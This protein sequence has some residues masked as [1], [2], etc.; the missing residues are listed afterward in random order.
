MSNVLEIN[1]KPLCSIREASVQVS[2]SRDYITRLAREDK[3]VATYIGRQWFVDI[4]SL[5]AYAESKAL[6]Q[7]IRSQH[8]SE[9]RKREQA[10]KAL[11]TKKTEQQNIRVGTFSFRAGAF[12]AVI[13]FC[14][15]GFGTVL[16]QNA[17]WLEWSAPR[18]VQAVDV[19]RAVVIQKDLN[20][21]D[22]NKLNVVPVDNTEPIDI[23][24]EATS[25]IKTLGE[26]KNGI[27]LLPAG[28]DDVS[29][30]DLF[31]DPVEVVRLK[32]GT[33]ALM[34]LDSRGFPV[35]EPIP[36]VDVPIIVKN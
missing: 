35:G 12:T 8:L 29:P 32:D 13:L 25:E 4:E 1:G 18:V 11:V 30:E 2:Y 10:Q 5:K 31:S 16:H 15:L 33:P 7:E 23:L 34:K 14:G 36:F 24:D 22:G 6:E 17:S 27:L 26:I 21:S 9:E 19:N 20:L 3:I 28:T